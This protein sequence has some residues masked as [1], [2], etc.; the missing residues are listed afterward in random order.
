MERPREQ[1]ERDAEP[2]PDVPDLEELRDAVVRLAR[3][4]DWLALMIEW[5]HARVRH[6]PG[7]PARPIFGVRTPKCT[8]TGRGSQGSQGSRGSR[9]FRG[10]EPP[11]GPVPPWEALAA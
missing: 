11:R 8:K 3:E 10:A 4:A 2:P 7:G 9:A 5:D 6:L 1:G